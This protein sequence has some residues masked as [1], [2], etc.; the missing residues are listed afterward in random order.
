M[1][2]HNRPDPGDVHSLQHPAAEVDRTRPAETC[3]LFATNHDLKV[4]NLEKK[5][6]HDFRWLSGQ[7]LATT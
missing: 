6:Q 5:S 3:L 7:R 1:A 4:R 2:G